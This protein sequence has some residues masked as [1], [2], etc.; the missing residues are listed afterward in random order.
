VLNRTLIAVALP[1]LALVALAAAGPGAAATPQRPGPRLTLVRNGPFTLA[2]VDRECFYAPGGAAKGWPWA[3]SRQI[4]P[5]RGSFNEVRALDGSHF[6]VDVAAPADD[7]DVYAIDG[8]KLV[9]R[10]KHTM[11]IAD[12]PTH[13]WSY[14]HLQSTTGWKRGM[15]VRRHELLGKIVHNYYHVHISEKVKGCQYVDPR[16]PTGNFWNPANTQK[17]IVGALSAYVADDA[18]WSRPPW[19]GAPPPPDPATPEALDDLHGVVDLRAL[20]MVPG[21]DTP[22]NVVGGQTHIPDLA[23]SAIR[24]WLTTPNRPDSH[25]E[26][27]LIMDGSRLVS[28]PYLWH[29]WAWGTWRDN[30]CLY[31]HPTCSQ[32]MVWHVG[33]QSGINTHAYPDGRYMY[34]VSALTINDAAATRCTEVAIRN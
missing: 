16:R 17:P 19:V 15:P 3:D 6:G 5:I 30:G 13:R 4:A 21:P 18:A 1:A 33:G 28:N 14:W 34:C 32:A 11:E 24:A 23:V 29:K 25:D 31:G 22:I 27:R 10:T 9:D 26:L 2:S 8:G 7:A 20:A 12:T